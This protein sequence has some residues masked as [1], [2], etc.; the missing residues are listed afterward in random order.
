MLGTVA[1]AKTRYAETDFSIQPIEITEAEHNLFGL[2]EKSPRLPGQ[3]NY[4]GE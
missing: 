4:Y 2:S 1:F 3:K